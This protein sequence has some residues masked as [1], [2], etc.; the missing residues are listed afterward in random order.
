MAWA[1]AAM[2]ALACCCAEQ[3]LSA[4]DLVRT[5]HTLTHLFHLGQVW[6]SSADGIQTWHLVSEEHA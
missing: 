2:A 3:P 4:A 5:D 1:M 6:T